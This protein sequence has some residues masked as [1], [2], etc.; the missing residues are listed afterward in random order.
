[1][2][3]YQMITDRIIEALER[4]TLPWKKPWIN[5]GGA[6]KHRDGKPY[7]LLNQ[8]LLGK[9]GEY[10]SFKEARMFGEGVRK[11]SKGHLVVFYKMLECQD[12]DVPPGSEPQ[13]KIVPL[14]RYHYVFHIDD[15]VGIDPKWQT[16]QFDTHEIE[17]PQTLFDEYKDRCFVG[18]LHE[19]N[20]H[21]FYRPSAHA[22]N[23]PSIE[24]FRS[25]EE[26]Y[27]TAFHEAVHSTGH[28]TLLNRFAEEGGCAEFGSESYSK[29]ELI[30][31][32]GSCAIMNRLGIETSDSFNNSAAYINGWLKAL[33]DDR[34]MVVTAA[35][36]AQK[37]VKLIMND[38]EEEDNTSED[39]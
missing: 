21:A 19:S 6:V 20:N 38:H 16:K 30:A 31:E 36:R 10:V 2:D 37:A 11:G 34:R 32:I 35:A 29:E 12:T 33:H 8:I 22:I 17:S 18:T 5:R 26:Y 4:G 7:S 25:A 1:M 9:E 23:L 39:I 15:C 27:S 13:T 24:Q 14:L 28:K 3:V